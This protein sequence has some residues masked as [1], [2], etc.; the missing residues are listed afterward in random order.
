MRRSCSTDGV[1]ARVD[2]LVGLALQRL[3]RVG[4]ERPRHFRRRLDREDRQRQDLDA[5][6]AHRLGLAS[7]AAHFGDDGVGAD[8]RLAQREPLHDRA[9]EDLRRLNEALGQ[10]LGII[11]E[12]LAGGPDAEIEQR[13]RA[14]AGR[15]RGTSVGPGG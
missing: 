1:A 2:R 14:G 3:A 6:H 10:L 4:L 5:E 15:R 12:V 9:G 13:R 7:A 11:G 8:Q